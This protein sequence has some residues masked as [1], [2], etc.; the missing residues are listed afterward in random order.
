MIKREVPVALTE[1][2][3]GE[4][5]GELITTTVDLETLESQ[6]RAAASQYRMKAKEVRRRNREI[7]R[8]LQ[9]GKAPRLMFVTER[10]RPD[11]GKVD[12]HL[13]QTGEY[14][15]QRDAM[16][17]EL[18]YQIPFLPKEGDF[19]PGNLVQIADFTAIFRIMQIE[20]S[21]AEIEPILDPEGDAPAKAVWVDVIKLKAAKMGPKEAPAAAAGPA[22]GDDDDEDEMEDL[23][24]GAEK[25]K[26]KST[27]GKRQRP[28]AEGKGKKRSGPKG[29][30]R[31]GGTA[32]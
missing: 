7:A 24:A 8:H 1:K 26:A 5:E 11:I 16:P 14:V 3:R 25:R 22:A 17:E 4:L 2:Q 19:K 15:D 28:P 32:H 20:D 23:P 21:R 29:V 12:I 31:G 30:I 10:L 6:A 13:A 18:T 27:P 9:A